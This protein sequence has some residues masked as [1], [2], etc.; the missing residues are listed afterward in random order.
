MS[1]NLIITIGRDFGAEGPE[2]GK[3]LEL[4]GK[5]NIYVL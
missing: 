3:E 4:T 5:L 1:S 2:I